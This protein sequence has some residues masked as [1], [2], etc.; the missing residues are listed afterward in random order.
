MLTPGIEMAKRAEARRQ[1]G[2]EIKVFG[3]NMPDGSLSQA[4]GELVWV[5]HSK[6]YWADEKREQRAG[7]D[8]APA[9]A[10]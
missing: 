1:P 4:A 5:K 9:P 3:V 8:S 10:A 7:R 6:H 2:G